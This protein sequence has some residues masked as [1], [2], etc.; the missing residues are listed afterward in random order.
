LVRKNSWQE[1]F[2]MKHPWKSRKWILTVYL[3]CVVLSVSAGP[4]MADAGK[5]KNVIVMVADGA[6]SAHT[7]IA[8][9]YKGEPLALDEM[10]VGGVRTYSADSLITDSAPAAT[11]FATG[12][13]SN[14][15]FIGVLYDRVAMPGIPKTRG[16]LRSKPLATVLE[17]AKLQGKA[18]GLVATS[19][20]Q[21]ATPA[22]YSAH[23]PDR[24]DYDEIAKQQV[25]LNIDVVLGGG[26]QY[27]LP[28][29]QGGAR[30]DGEDLVEI[31]KQKGH[32]FIQ[33][34][35]ELIHAEGKKV[36]GMFA[37]DAL[38]NDFDRAKF[39]PQEPSLAEMT[40]AA[41]RL[42]S[43]NNKG[44]FLFVEGS[45]ID[46]AAHANEPV[47][48]ISELLA[49]DD[50]VAAA[51][52]FAKKDGRTLI[53]AFSDHGTG[54][55]SLGSKSTEKSHDRL[56]L[57]T[58]VN[59][60]KKAVLTGEGLEKTLGGDFS[61]S[62]IINVVSQYYGI[63][64]LKPEEIAA[65][66]KFTKGDLKSAVGPMLSK[67]TPIGWINS[68]H[69]GEDL[70]LYAY[71]PNRPVGLLENTEIAHICARSFGFELAAIDN[72]LFSPAQQL[73][74]PLG[75]K[76]SIDQSN[77]FQSALIVEKGALRL[78]FP[79]SQNIMKKGDQ[80]FEMEGLTVFAPKAER[81]YLPR[82]AAE[83]A[84]KAGM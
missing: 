54:G 9:W 32:A 43:R 8:R 51:L 20:I 16:D 64:D 30:K 15:K 80:V 42:L 14:D 21:H 56:R 82:Q 23:T 26:K 57:E 41:L 36:W 17:G 70:F 83:L 66:Q 12:H 72:R 28:P 53:L 67:R 25:Y 33:T 5:V 78:E 31:L 59:P 52:E 65:I 7:T 73:F 61:E 29:W 77:P 63:S 46:W 35:D 10:L 11:A 18:V 27:L 24:R 47:G 84:K 50:A 6:G 45:K 81:V 76:L 74:Q 49:F 3:F 19:N 68:G 69:T 13:K 34:R 4:V 71:G 75:A 79:F 40:R 39:A 1:G 22:A 38:A 58:L 37:D 55:M 60:L 62:N 2:S 44:F 48:V